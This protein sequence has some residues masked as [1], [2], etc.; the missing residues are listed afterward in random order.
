MTPYHYAVGGSLGSDAP[1][2]VKRQADEDLYKG[3]KAGEFCNVLNSRQ[4]GKSS[5]RVRTMQRLQ[6]EGIACAAIDLTSIGSQQVTLEQWYAGIIRRLSSGFK[7]TNKTNMKNWWNEHRDLSSLHRLTEFIENILLVEIDRNIIIFVDEIDSVLSLDFKVDDFFKFIRFC[8]NNRADRPNYRRL[9]FSMLGVASPSD[10]IQDCHLSPPFNIGRSIELAGFKLNE[11]QPLCQGLIG[12]ARRPDSVLTEVL[13]WTE[14]Q[15]FLTQKICRLIQL[16]E[17][18]IPAGQESKMVE[19]IVRSKILNNWEFQDEPSHLRDI[20]NRLIVSNKAH[21]LKLYSQILDRGE[22]LAKTNPEYFDLQLSGAV[23]K[24]RGKLTIFNRIYTEVFDRDWLTEVENSG[25]ENER[26]F[27]IDDSGYKQLEEDKRTPLIS[28]PPISGIA[29]DVTDDEQ[30]IYDHWLYWVERET[31]DRVID[32]F[33][34]LFLVGTTYSDKK[35][36]ASLDLICQLIDCESRFKYLLNRCCTILINNWSKKRQR[37]SIVELVRLFDENKYESQQF[38]VFSPV[39][40]RLQEL[41][42]VF[43]QSE[44]FEEIKSLAAIDEPKEEK[45]LLETMPLI[46][47]IERSPYLAPHFLNSQNRSIEEQKAIRRR[48]HKFAVDLL[49]YLSN[50]KETRLSSPNPTILRDDRLEKALKEFIGKVEDSSTYKEISHRFLNQLECRSY[51]YRE[52]KFYL[53]KYLISNVNSKYGKHSFYQRL[54][55]QLAD[56]FPELN[57]R[58]ID[59]LLVRQTCHRLLEFLVA[60]PSDPQKFK[61]FIDLTGCLGTTKTMGLLLKIALLSHGVEPNSRT[62]LE[63]RFAVLFEHYENKSIDPIAKD[64]LVNSLG[65]FNVAMATNFSQIDISAFQDF[66]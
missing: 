52:F 19:E 28:H 48:Q 36:K 45:V 15:P 46:Q 20:Q 53:Y 39:A 8:Y 6:A 3:L 47:L 56:T 35:V 62:N 59:R 11:A 61:L 41:R 54:D 2:Y 7:L 50:R 31:P 34:K 10:L 1:T 64:W 17:L 16:S 65:N 33:K 26:T 27:T 55:R 49:E 25:V 30:I 51:S 18:F 37:Q 38:S 40:D 5:L 22:I 32:R 13:Y 21:V 42:S 14:G 12:K 57:H 58:P 43:T 66:L 29:Y 63:T 24:K 9:S 60:S 4:M 23:V 44:E